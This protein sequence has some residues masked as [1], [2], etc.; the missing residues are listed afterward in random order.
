[1][2][3]KEASSSVVEKRMRVVDESLKVALV[4]VSV[5]GVVV[6]VKLVAKLVKQ[7]C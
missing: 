2:W 3:S 7:L 4:E 1:M 5:E 6:E